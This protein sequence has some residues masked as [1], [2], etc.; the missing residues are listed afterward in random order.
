MI[1]ELA[2]AK[3]SVGSRICLGSDVCKELGV[4]KGDRVKIGRNAEGE[5]TLAK[6]I[7]AAKV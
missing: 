4:T 5:I 2:I 6:I 3:I 7:S 1:E